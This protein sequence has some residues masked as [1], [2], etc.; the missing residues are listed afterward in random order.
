MPDI[1]VSSA[2]ISMMRNET[3]TDSRYKDVIITAAVDVLV[4]LLFRFI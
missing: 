1:A 4:V 2:V 3:A